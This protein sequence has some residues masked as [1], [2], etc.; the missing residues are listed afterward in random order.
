MN[1]KNY[2]QIMNISNKSLLNL[3]QKLKNYKIYQQNLNNKK[4]NYK[5]KIN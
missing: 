2:N 4:K 5:L 3:N 1:Q